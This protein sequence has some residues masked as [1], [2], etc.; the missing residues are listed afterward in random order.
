MLG[1]VLG[2][3]GP[4]SYP[5]LPSL[6][7]SNE[8]KLPD[9]RFPFRGPDDSKNP[10]AAKLVQGKTAGNLDDHPRS[11]SVGESKPSTRSID[12]RIFLDVNVVIRADE[13][14]LVCGDSSG[15]LMIRIE[16]SSV[17][18]PFT[19]RTRTRD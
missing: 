3:G 11:R 10:V 4:I 7:L 18:A 8:G 13:H 19:T 6:S 1:E 5:T 12:L 16:A 14:A 9:D 15:I 17:L 2:R